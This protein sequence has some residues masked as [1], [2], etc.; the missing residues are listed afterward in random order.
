MLSHYNSIA[1]NKRLSEHFGIISSKIFNKH[2]M[3]YY[4]QL[5][6]NLCT[7]MKTILT[8]LLMY[9]YTGL[10][11]FVYVHMHIRT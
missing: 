8:G 9:A 1:N 2:K 7:Q 6:I 11:V 5:H 3:M 4:Q 10:F